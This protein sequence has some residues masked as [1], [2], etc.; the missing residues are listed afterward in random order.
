M[1]MKASDNG[2][3]PYDYRNSSGKKS[4]VSPIRL[5][6]DLINVEFLKKQ[7]KA[8]AMSIKSSS[9]LQSDTVGIKSER[10]ISD[11]KRLLDEFML[12]HATI[13]ACSKKEKKEGECNFLK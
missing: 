1:R 6:N 8:K 9:Q 11:P 3:I 4:S 10:Q 12:P 5:K 7:I 13:M 2:V